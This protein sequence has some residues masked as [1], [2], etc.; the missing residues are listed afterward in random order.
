MEK[1]RKKW[2]NASDG[3]NGTAGGGDRR[4]CSDSVVV[5]W[6]VWVVD[7]VVY[8]RKENGDGERSVRRCGE[9]KGEEG[10]VT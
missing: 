7:L 9:M 6:S 5:Q 8:G 3:G 1:M 2:R 10:K 4:W